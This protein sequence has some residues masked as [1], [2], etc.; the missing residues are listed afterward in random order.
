MRDALARIVETKR[1]EIA[2][3]EAPD[4]RAL[5]PSD[6]DFRAAL[7]RP[8][9]ADS[10]PGR[11]GRSLAVIAE[12]KRRSPSAGLLRGE[13]DPAARARTYEAGGAAAVSVLTDAAHFGGNGADLASARTAV[14]LPVLRKDFLLA[15]L[16][17][18]E[19]RALGA[20]AVLLIAAALAPAE[21]REMALRAED[22][23]MTALVEVHDERELEAALAIEPAVLGI[24]NRSLRDLTIDPETIHRLAPL[25]PEGIV[26]VSESGIRDP[27]SVRDLPERVDAVLVGSALMTCDDPSAFV[28]DAVRARE[29][30]R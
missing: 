14:S 5:V 21:L 4:R 2:R 28:R 26:L 19:S 17:I 22:L 13:C 1:R 6:R 3:L 16:Q 10:A 8:R 27:E 11:T 9:P 30:V 20:D 15:P 24:N 23:G 25:V 29:A 18:A 7:D 12:I